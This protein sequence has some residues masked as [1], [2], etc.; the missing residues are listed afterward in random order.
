MWWEWSR[1]TIFRKNCNV[2]TLDP[3]AE[4]A[5][6]HESGLALDTDDVWC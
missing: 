5:D 2:E 6:M 1:E 3:G 4:K